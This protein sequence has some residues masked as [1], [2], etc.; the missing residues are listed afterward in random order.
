MRSPYDRYKLGGDESAISAA[1]KRGEGVFNSRG[2]AQC[3]GGWNL[4]AVRT[5]GEPEGAGSGL[6]FN[7]GL[8]YEAP[9]RGLYENTGRYDDFGKFRAPTLRNIALTDPYMHDGSLGTLE[10]VIDHYASGGALDQANKTPMLRPFTVTEEEKSDLVEFL[11]SLTDQEL[12][13]DPRW[14]DPWPVSPAR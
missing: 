14:S 5:E 10:A 6:F 12:L 3:H 4:G 8:E 11:K 1:A 9:N 2:C 7:T 13:R